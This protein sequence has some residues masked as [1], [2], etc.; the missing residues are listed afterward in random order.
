[1]DR[2]LFHRALFCESRESILIRFGLRYDESVLMEYRTFRIYEELCSNDERI[3]IS[4]RLATMPDFVL[5]YVLIHELAHLLEAN[6]G[7][8][9]WDLVYRYPKTERARGFLIGAGYVKSE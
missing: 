6:H 2:E 8:Q 5:D 7:R 9:F 1:M 3:R 4:H